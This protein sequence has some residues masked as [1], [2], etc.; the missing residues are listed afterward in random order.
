MQLVTKIDFFQKLL[1]FSWKHSPVLNCTADPACTCIWCAATE[2]TGETPQSRVAETTQLQVRR[3]WV[4]PSSC[5]GDAVC[6]LPCLLPPYLSAAASPS[7]GARRR[8][9]PLTIVFVA[10]PLLPLPAGP[11]PLFTLYSCNMNLSS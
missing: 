2:P 6:P 11:S 4:Y 3:H 1:F 5:L 8:D 7:S 9:L 10:N